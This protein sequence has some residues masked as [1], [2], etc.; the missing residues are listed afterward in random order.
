LGAGINIAVTLP[1]SILLSGYQKEWSPYSIPG[2][3]I[4]YKAEN[5][6]KKKMAGTCYLV[7]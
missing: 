1:A 3:R 4:K 5:Y 2:Q 6:L 7:K